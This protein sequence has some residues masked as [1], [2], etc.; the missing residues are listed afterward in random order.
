MTGLQPVFI[1]GI[2]SYKPNA[3]RQAALNKKRRQVAALQSRKFISVN[4]AV[5]SVVKKSINSFMLGKR[6][7]K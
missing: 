2:Y 6:L 4:S 3:V 5:F 1:V 7:I